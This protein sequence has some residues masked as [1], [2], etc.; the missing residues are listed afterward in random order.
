MFL[1]D[2]PKPFFVLAPMDDVTDTVFRQIVSGCASPD[3]YFTE[4]TNV[5]GL[6]SPGRAKLLRKLRFIRSETSL[7]AHIWGLK[8]EN[9]YKTAAEI[10]NGTMA[11]E[12][13]LPEGCNF[14]GIDL[15][16][17]CPAKSEV[18][19][20]ACS[21]LMNNRELAVEI[22]K[23]TQEGAGGKLPVSVK[24]R[25]GFNDIDL[26]WPTLL[27]EQKLNMLSMH[28]R[29]RKQMSKVP[30]D[31]ASI[32]EVRELRDKISPDTLI[33]GNGDVENRAQGLELANKYGLDGIMIGRGV[34]H[35]PFAFSSDSPWDNY[36]KAQRIELYTKHVKLFVETWREGERAVHTLN[37][38][39]KIYINGFDGAKELRERLM[40]ANSTVELLDILDRNKTL[41]YLAA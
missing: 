20:G 18:K 41:D 40:M 13:G 16:M 19:S 12:L 21:A 3:L 33:V 37:K 2:L 25:L 6:Q 10:A 29:T 39:C 38:F 36:S 14:V 24:T 15:N 11:R 32:G 28:G 22:I 17:G 30:A 7:V 9:F 23:A 26:T 1:Q 27:L 31:W 8:P 35:D 34:F 5:D 4:F